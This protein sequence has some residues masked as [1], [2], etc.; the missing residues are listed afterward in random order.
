MKRDEMIER[1]GSN[2]SKLNNEHPE[3]QYWRG[4]EHK[5]ATEA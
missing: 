3:R 4:L 1:G 5:F 2:F